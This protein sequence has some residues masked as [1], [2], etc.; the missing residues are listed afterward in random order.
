MTEA[1]SSESISG[2]RILS[3]HAGFENCNSQFL[4]G[5]SDNR[6]NR[7][8]RPTLLPIILGRRSAHPRSRLFYRY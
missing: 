1:E 8:V 5:K 6:L 4:R 2:R 3:D 7:L